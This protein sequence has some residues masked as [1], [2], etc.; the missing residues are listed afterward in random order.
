MQ[1]VGQPFRAAAALS[2]RR[3]GQ[4]PGGGPKA[5]PHAGNP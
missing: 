1:G 3:A 2:A 5:R 4:Q